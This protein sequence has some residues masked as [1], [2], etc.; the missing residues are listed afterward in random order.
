MKLSAKQKEIIKKIHERGKVK[1]TNNN[2]L[3]Y[4]TTQS[5]IKLGICEYNSGYDSL[6]LTELGKQIVLQP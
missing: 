5:L 3:P 2:A 1:I 4:S 6:I